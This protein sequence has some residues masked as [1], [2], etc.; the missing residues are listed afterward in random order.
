MISGIFRWLGA[1]GGGGSR[2]TLETVNDSFSYLLLEI[3][4]FFIIIFSERM[5]KIL[6]RRISRVCKQ[7]MSLF[8]SHVTYFNPWTRQN[9]P[10]PLKIEQTLSH[11]KKPRHRLS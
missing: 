5:S 2:S 1:D 11:R 7:L 4:Y 9:F 10:A 8:V 3:S 6:L